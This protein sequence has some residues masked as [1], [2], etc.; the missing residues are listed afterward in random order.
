MVVAQA[1]GWSRRQ[2]GRLRRAAHRRPRLAVLRRISVGRAAP[3]LERRQCEL[4]VD[5]ADRPLVVPRSDRVTVDIAVAPPRWLGNRE[6]CGNLGRGLRGG[7][8][9]AL[10]GGR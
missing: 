10:F 8:P 5:R 9:G 4:A 3:A 2:D 1:S 7:S 6:Y